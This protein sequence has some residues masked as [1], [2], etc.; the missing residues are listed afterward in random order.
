MVLPAGSSEADARTQVF[1][2]DPR[3]AVRA[4]PTGDHPLVEGVNELA[5]ISSASI[6]PLTASPPELLVESAPDA[7]VMRPLGRILPDADHAAL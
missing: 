2:R 6:W 7:A 1:S 4:R 5:L 3:L